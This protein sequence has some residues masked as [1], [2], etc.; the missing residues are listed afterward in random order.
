MGQLVVSVV[1][2]GLGFLVGGPVGAKVGFMLGSAV[3]STLFAPTIEGPRLNDLKVTASTLGV[4]IPEMV[5]TVRLGG[6]MI[7]TTGIKEREEEVSTGGKGGGPSQ[8]VYKY[9]ASFAMAICKGPID[10][11]TRIWADGKLI[12][13]KTN[14]NGV[15]LSAF[16][17][18]LFNSGN[19]LAVFVGILFREVG[20]NFVFGGGNSRIRFRLYRGTED[21]LPD[22]LIVADKGAGNVSAHRGLAY[23][24]VENM[25]L[26]DFGN[27]IPQLTFEVTRAPQKVMSILTAKNADGTALTNFNSGADFFP[28]WDLGVAWG[29]TSSTAYA[30]DLTTMEVMF[31]DGGANAARDWDTNFYRRK[32]LQGAGIWLHTEGTRNSAALREWNIFSISQTGIYGTTSNSTS[33]F[34]N[35]DNQAGTVGFGASNSY[36]IG[37]LGV[38]GFCRTS[39]SSRIYLTINFTRYVW[40]LRTGLEW[41]AAGDFQVPWLPSRLIEGR[42]FGTSADIIGY[43]SSGGQLQIQQWYISAGIDYDV[44]QTPDGPDWRSGQDYQVTTYNLNPFSVASAAFRNTSWTFNPWVVLYDETDDCIFALGEV[45]SALGEEVAAMKYQ[46]STEQIKFAQ[47]YFR[48]VVGQIRLPEN[49]MEY[50]RI[51]GGTFGW[52]TRAFSTQIEEGLYEIDLQTGAFID[53]VRYGNQFGNRFEA[54]RGSMH[55]DDRTRS[56]VSEAEGGNDTNNRYVR[57][58]FGTGAA[59]L[60]IRDVVR[61]ICLSTRMLTD[62][63]IDVSQLAD[64]RLSGYIVDRTTTA[65]AVLRQLATGF[66][67]DGYESDYKLVFRSR[68]RSP[69]VTIPED[70]IA[71]NSEQDIVSETVTQEVELPMR[72]TMNYYDIT[73]DHNQG[74]QTVKRVSKPVPSMLSEREDVIDLPVVWTPDRAKQGADKLLKMAWASRVNFDFQLPWRY[75]KYNPSDVA[76]IQ[77][78]SGTTHTVRMGEMNIGGDFSL[79]VRGQSEK[80]SAYDSDLTGS[81]VDTPLQTIADNFPAVAEALNTPL[82]RD[83]DFDPANNARVYLGVSTLSRQ[84]AGAAVFVNEGFDFVNQGSLS[85]KLVTGFCQ[86][87]LPPTTSWA[88]TDNKT[89]FL[90]RLN[91]RSQVLE[92]VTQEEML[93]DGVNAALVGDE[94]IQFRD[95]TQQSDG[96]WLLTGLLRARRGTNYAVN[97]H[98]QGDRFILL[99]APKLLTDLR[100]PSSYTI[101]I[102]TKA[103]PRRTRLGEAE[104]QTFDLT[105]RDLQPLTPEGFEISESGS[106]VTIRV[107]RRSRITAPLVAGTG[108]IHY[109]EGDKLSAKITYEVWY[110][111]RLSDIEPFPDPDVSGEMGLFN[112]S[113]NDVTAEFTLPLGNLDPPGHAL[114]RLIEIGTVPGIPKWVEIE[115]AAPGL[116]NFKELY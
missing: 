73:R 94:I 5:G 78:A 105:P 67:F 9:S 25:E 99:E 74:T 18:S 104:P 57:I 28:D 14:S 62:A 71:R 53:N 22:S 24:V 19:A 27:R 106:D 103:V 39:A 7:W 84:F 26:E 69:D 34:V 64:D 56:L 4:V 113:G 45:N 75:L 116:W 68:G 31:S 50:S 80:A 63:D 107:Q 10:D 108:T 16:S 13:D 58:F 41:P 55:W 38:V 61:E 60:T 72:I 49:R 32:Y 23:I 2:A 83:V 3:G 21:Q 51:E 43:R 70:W 110:G 81:L 15:P 36:G 101:T 95:A 82:L 100:P 20:G 86:T 76:Q 114:I 87:V 6:N 112:A 91:D 77:L 1:G 85:S 37:N 8:T 66:L 42:K 59:D 54:L 29:V 52:G 96:S 11:L 79:V 48:D 98:R 47:I 92:S 35:Y 40:I 115:R 44:V 33:G 89:Q 90:V 65:R 17:D 109:K 30:I 46:R 111:L 12:Y 93:N 88:S 102:Q 97:S